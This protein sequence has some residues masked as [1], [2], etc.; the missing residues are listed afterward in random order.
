MVGIFPV[1]DNMIRDHRK[2]AFY[3]ITDQDP[4]K[5]MSMYTGMGIGEHYAGSNWEDRA[6][7]LQGPAALTVRDAAYRLLLAQGF[8]E[9]EIP[10]PLR[11]Q[12][13]PNGYDARVAQEHA[14]LSAEWHASDEHGG[15]HWGYEAD[16]GPSRWGSMDSEWIMCAE[17][18]EQSPI[19]LHECLDDRAWSG[20]PPTKR[21]GGGGAKP[22]GCHRRAR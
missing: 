13:K 11:P 22:R 8:D 2:I 7:M 12:Q 10:L 14:A 15:N 4:Y 9:N 19:D 21:T 1:P 20:A 6:I 16:N 3:D 5:G 18:R 17:G